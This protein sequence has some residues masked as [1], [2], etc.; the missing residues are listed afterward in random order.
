MDRAGW[1]PA[2]LS[3]IEIGYWKLD[4]G[5]SKIEGKIN[6]LDQ[7]QISTFKFQLSTFK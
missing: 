2:V 5:N 3:K 1:R 4:T 7:L 6:S